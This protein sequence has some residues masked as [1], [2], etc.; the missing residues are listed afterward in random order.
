MNTIP[1]TPAQFVLLAEQTLACAR[2]RRR[3]TV[4]ETEGLVGLVRK[5][6]DKIEH[7]KVTPIL[8]ALT[9]VSDESA[10]RILT[11]CGFDSQNRPGL[12][13]EHEIGV[14]YTDAAPLT[15][16]DLYATAKTHR[17]MRELLAHASEYRFGPILPRALADTL[18]PGEVESRYGIQVQRGSGGQWGLATWCALWD[19]QAQGWTDGEGWTRFDSLGEALDQVP[20]ALAAR[21][22][23]TAGILAD[24]LFR[25]LTGTPTPPEASP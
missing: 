10:D 19:A 5:L 25:A 13:D 11:W 16:G 17:Q 12:G 7:L 4:E 24:H 18:G 8:P 2:A 3:A 21:F 1:V 15:R 20:A 14:S 9:T 6:A 23:E 22:H